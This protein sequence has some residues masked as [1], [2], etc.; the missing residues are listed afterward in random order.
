M[1]KHN[2]YS[3]PYDMHNGFCGNRFREK[4]E[5]FQ[6]HFFDGGARFAKGGHP[7]YRNEVPVNIIEHASFFEL[8]VYAA[9]RKKEN[10]HVTIDQDLLT[11][12]YTLPE[13]VKEDT[14]VYQEFAAE[15]FERSFQVQDHV[16]KDAVHASFEDG[17]LTVVLPK[18][19]DKNKPA[20]DVRVD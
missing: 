19:P 14:F 18:D 16:K 20:Q 4:F 1:F 12:S 9:G 11:V 17:I 3:R 15:A 5:K 10:F 7:R 13:D 8:K 6:Q 2:Q